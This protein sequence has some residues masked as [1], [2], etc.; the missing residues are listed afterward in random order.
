[1]AS[2]DDVSRK[3]CYMEKET[4]QKTTS[5]H[6]EEGHIMSDKDSEQIAL[7]LDWIVKHQILRDTVDAYQKLLPKQQYQVKQAL[8]DYAKVLEETGR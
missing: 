2:W 6:P 3:T 8:L 1:M 7:L 4:E 5:E